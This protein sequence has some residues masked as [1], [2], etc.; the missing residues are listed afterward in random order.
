MKK[1]FLLLLFSLSIVSYS[2]GDKIDKNTLAPNIIINEKV[3]E[4]PKDKVTIL[5]F[6]QST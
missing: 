3:L 4:L 5:K 1:L 2:K 6:W